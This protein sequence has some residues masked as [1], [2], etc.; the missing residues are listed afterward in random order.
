M[1]YSTCIQTP[2]E[3][4][5][6]KTYLTKPNSDKHEEKAKLKILSTKKITEN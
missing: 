4:L 2:H 1:T 5:S 3:N 6:N